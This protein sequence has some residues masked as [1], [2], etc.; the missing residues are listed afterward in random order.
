MTRILFVCLGNICRSPTAQGVV[1]HQVDQ[2]GWTER[3]EL[4]SAGTA[5]YH[6]GEPPDRRAIHAARQRGIDISQQRARA[7]SVA[8]FQAFDYVI[9][10][11]DDNRGNLLTLAPAGERNRVHLMMAFA[12][13]AGYREVPDPY[14]GGESGF[15][16]VLD[17]LEVA[18][19]GLLDHLGEGAD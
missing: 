1:Q 2:R 17:L 8:D 3:Y 10:M 19:R 9:A 16:R 14:Y 7:I 12:P 11:D 4:D 15:E 18:G 5:A 13:D 6:V